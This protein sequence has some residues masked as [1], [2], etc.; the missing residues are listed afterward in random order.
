MLLARLLTTPGNA[1]VSEY[2]RNDK[3]F[4]VQLYQKFSV[5]G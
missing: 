1:S 4:V 2:N 5:S 3:V